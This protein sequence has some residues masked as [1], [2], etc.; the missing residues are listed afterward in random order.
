[1][2]LSHVAARLRAAPAG[3]APSQHK[4][5]QRLS[6]AVV[7][8]AAGYEVRTVQDLHPPRITHAL[9]PRSPSGPWLIEPH[10]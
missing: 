10:C 8:V 3:L 7:I 4:T 5:L 6:D 2:A 1:M 9:G